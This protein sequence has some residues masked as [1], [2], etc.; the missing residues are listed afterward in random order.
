MC[1]QSAHQLWFWVECH[2]CAADHGTS[3]KSKCGGT[4]IERLLCSSLFSL[5]MG[6]VT[7]SNG[8]APSCE[9]T[10]SRGVKTLEGLSLSEK[11]CLLTGLPTP[12]LIM[13]PVHLRIQNRRLLWDELCLPNAC[14]KVPSSSGPQN[15][16][17]VGNGVFNRGNQVNMRSLGKL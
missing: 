2:P 3:V 17:L 9:V 15:V 14:V 8:A 5:L 1:I 7:K 10:W 13:T 16:S 6:K 11:C 4:A 12:H